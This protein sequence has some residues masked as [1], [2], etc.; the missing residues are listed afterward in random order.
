MPEASEGVAVLGGGGGWPGC[1]GALFSET[2]PNQSTWLSWLSKG[3]PL[4]SSLIRPA[5]QIRGGKVRTGSKSQPRT[6][7]LYLDVR[8]CMIK[9]FDF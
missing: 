5:L 1:R 7:L 6:R 9:L 3:K 2:A 4:S 8:Q